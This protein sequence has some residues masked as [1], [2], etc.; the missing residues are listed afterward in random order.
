MAVLQTKGG[1][2]TSPL[3]VEASSKSSME[4]F[5][6]LGTSPSGLTEAAATERLEKYG[7]NEVASEEKHGWWHRLYTA[8]IP[9]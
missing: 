4:V 9:L 7:P 5:Q 6:M 8:A 3:L 2:Q 1:I